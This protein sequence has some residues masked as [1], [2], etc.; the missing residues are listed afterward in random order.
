MLL[1]FLSILSMSSSTS[2][3]HLAVPALLACLVVWGDL[4]AE[5]MVL[6][7]IWGILFCCAGVLQGFALGPS[8]EASLLW[9]LALP[10]GEESILAHAEPSLLEPVY[11]YAKVTIPHLNCLHTN[12]TVF[13]DV[14]LL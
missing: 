13:D 10:A 4:C 6:L 3:G 2:A 12:R 14:K 11:S 1:C 9:S 7:V 5:L 8:G